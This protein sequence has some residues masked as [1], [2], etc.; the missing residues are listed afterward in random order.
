MCTRIDHYMFTTSS[1]RNELERRLSFRPWLYVS[2]SVDSLEATVHEP[3][4]SNLAIIDL[5]K[6]L[7]LIKFSRAYEVEMEWCGRIYELSTFSCSSSFEARNLIVAASRP[8][9]N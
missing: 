8:S 7:E 4:S 6:C 1:N 2:L 9:N 5:S 3:V